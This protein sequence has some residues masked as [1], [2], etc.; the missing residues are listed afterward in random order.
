M[1]CSIT[2]ILDPSPYPI[3]SPNSEHS[4]DSEVSAVR[5]ALQ[6]DI[7]LNGSNDPIPKGGLG[8]LYE[9]PLKSKGRGRHYHLHKGQEKSRCELEVGKQSSID[10][11]LRSPKAQG[12]VSN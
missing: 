4:L 3:V 12:G 10:W 6:N 1:V 5:Y 8:K 9:K 2:S 11:E 7:I